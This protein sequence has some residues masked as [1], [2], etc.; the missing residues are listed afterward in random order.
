MKVR[1]TGI[2]FAIASTIGSPRAEVQD[3]LPEAPIPL[4]ELNAIH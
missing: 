1:T 2:P 3:E 4:A